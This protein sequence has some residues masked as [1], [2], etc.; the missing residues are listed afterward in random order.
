MRLLELLQV[1]AV[2]LVDPLL[3]VVQEVPL[4]GMILAAVPVLLV[5]QLLVVLE[6]ALWGANACP[7]CSPGTLPECHG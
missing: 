6:K 4:W 7:W 2:V 3:V 1:L 5:V